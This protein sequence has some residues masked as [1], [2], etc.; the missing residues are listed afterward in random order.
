M[1]SCLISG[2]WSVLWLVVIGPTHA[3]SPLPADGSFAAQGHIQYLS[4][5]SGKLTLPQV[6]RDSARFR[7]VTT[8]RLAFGIG[9]PPHWLRFRVS[10]PTAGSV[11]LVVE[12]DNQYLTSVQLYL[13]AVTGQLIHDSGP[14][15]WAHLPRYRTSNHR[16]PLLACRLWPGEQAWVYG[17][18]DN[19]SQALRIPIRLWTASAFEVHDRQQRLFWYGLT[20]ILCWLV[21]TNLVLF[22]L[23]RERVYGLYSLYMFVVT[24]YLTVSAGFWLEW[25][26]TVQY[27]AI[28]TRQLLSVITAIST[29]VGFFFIKQYVLLPVWSIARI[30]LAFQTAVHLLTTALILVLVGTRVE[31]LYIQ[32]IRW[33]GPLMSVLF[34]IPVLLMFG[35]IGYQALRTD[36]YSPRGL[37]Q[38]PARS[39]LL[40]VTPLVIVSLLLILRNHAVLAD[41]V[42][43]GYEGVALGY[44]FEFAVLSIGLGF[45]YKRTAD[46][47][48]WLAEETFIQREQLL[49]TQLKAKQDEL[50]ATQTQ[51]HIQQERERISRD[52]HDHV[53]AQLSVIVANAHLPDDEMRVNGVAI[54]DYA[55]EAMQSLRDTVWAIDQPSVS[56]AGFRGKLQQYLNRQQQQHPACIYQL[57]YLADEPIE[58]TSAQALNLFRQVQEAIHNAFKHARAS[59]VWVRCRL[60]NGQLT[61]SVT[62][63]GIGFNPDQSTDGQPHYGLRNLHQRAEELQGQ[64]QIDSAPGRG[65]QVTIT[66]PLVDW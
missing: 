8:S 22:A 29:L 55:R 4:D 13:V 18:F 48:R 57:D 6:W 32:E 35:L 17:R 56:L 47:R 65:T 7:L 26:P 34:G 37:W 44:L 61:L 53:G 64:C 30:R 20:G 25:F 45:R 14:L 33:L 42:L 15:G 59:Q 49:E 40:A 9:Q 31:W 19:P 54:G 1:R 36:A 50:R 60:A 63:N 2:L 12:V 58:L 43:F 52:L 27:G 16:N 39:Y 21:F 3:Q 5:S 11:P 46:E 10:N 24:A 23:L 51:L 41:H 38:S 62:D 66:I 28:N